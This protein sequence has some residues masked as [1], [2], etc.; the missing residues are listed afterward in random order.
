M[1]EE[2]V[3]DLYDE[4]DRRE[5]EAIWATSTLN[6]ENVAVPF[7]PANPFLSATRNQGRQ[8]LARF[9]RKEFAGLLTDVLCDARRR[10]KIASLRPLDTPNLNSFYNPPL[11]NEN[12]LELSDDEPIYDPVASDD[13]YAPI[14]PISQQFLQF[15]SFPTG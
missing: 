13:D 14:P 6:G 12:E 15:L 10:Q 11:L 1:F 3:M 9:S 8:K 2:L 5:N 4:V 7:L